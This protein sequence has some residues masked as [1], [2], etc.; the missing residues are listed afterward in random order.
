MPGS[1]CLSGCEDKTC[2]NKGEYINSSHRTGVC[3]PPLGAEAI[4]ES[5]KNWD[6]LSGK[7]ERVTA[8]GELGVWMQGEMSTRYA[9][10]AKLRPC[11]FK[12]SLG[13]SISEQITSACVISKTWCV[14]RA[15]GL[16][17]WYLL[18]LH[19]RSRRSSGPRSRA[20]SKARC[21]AC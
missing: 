18:A 9:V 20:R 2:V 19:E 14:S 11:P 15:S 21:A 13:S 10:A 1:G 12:S 16:R 6:N 17:Q 7:E 4:E 8:D 5:S 3:T